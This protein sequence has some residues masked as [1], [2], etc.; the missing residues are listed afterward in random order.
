MSDIESEKSTD[1]VT[2]KINNNNDFKNKADVETH[3]Q[4]HMRAET[5][6]SSN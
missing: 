1:S 3:S 5:A 4:Y 2:G 6:T